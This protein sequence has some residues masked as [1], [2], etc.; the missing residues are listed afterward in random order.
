MKLLHMYV[1]VCVPK[2]KHVL[3]CIEVFT[4]FTMTLRIELSCTLFLVITCQM[5]LQLGVHLW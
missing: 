2:I 5:F 3:N 1:C 4:V